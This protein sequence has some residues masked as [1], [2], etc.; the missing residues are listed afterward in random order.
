MTSKRKTTLLT[1]QGLRKW[2][3]WIDATH[4]KGQSKLIKEANLKLYDRGLLID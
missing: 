3:E 1:A 2:Q 4:D